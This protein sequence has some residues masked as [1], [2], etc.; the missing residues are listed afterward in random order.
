MSAMAPGDVP[1]GSFLT[2]SESIDQ[3]YMRQAL[4]LARRG[5]GMT[6]PNP[7]VGAVVVKDGVIVGRGFHRRPGEDHAEV[8]AL[9]QAGRSTP[10]STLYVNLEPC[11]FQGRTPPCTEEILSRGVARV[12][13]AQEDPNPRVSGQGIA[14]LRSAGVDVVCGVLRLQAE[15]LNEAY[16]KHIRTGLPLVVVKMAQSL[17]GRIATRDGDSQ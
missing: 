8:V 9:R 1:S 6:S 16:R 7:C 3:R 15:K 14:L 4:R 11:C 5:I 12:V 10:G 13:C 17:D 2:M